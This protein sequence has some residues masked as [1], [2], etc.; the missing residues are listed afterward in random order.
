MD[1]QI[2][3]Q[4]I[5]TVGLVVVAWIGNRK[6][7]RIGADAKEA[8]N[9]TANTHETNLRD[10]LD[11][12]HA[13]VREVTRQVREVYEDLQSV[14][15]DVRGIRRDI[16]GLRADDGEIRLQLRLERERAMQALEDHVTQTQR[17]GGEGPLR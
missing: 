3:V 2:T 7:N 14:H 6:L 15:G 17:A 16:N 1:T 4:I 8:R 9:Q 12:L 5:A 13:G 10:D 11:D